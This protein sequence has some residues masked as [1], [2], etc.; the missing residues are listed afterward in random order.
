VERCARAALREAIN[1]A[2]IPAGLLESELFGHVRGAFTGATKD[3][4]GRFQTANGG[5]LLLDEIGELPLELQAKLLRVLQEGTFEP[6]GSDRTVRVD[7]RIIAATH[8]D[9]ETRRR[10]GRFRA[11]LYYRL[12]VFPLRLPA[13][14]ERLE[15]LD[16][17]S[18][19]L[20][21]SLARRTGRRGG[22]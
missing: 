4:A 18:E 19:A 7:V 12:N 3:R 8:V 9:L 6:V 10:R 13:L 17:L 1:C 2:A 20:L 11:D 15:D 21:A 14:R 22:W 16:T 5:T